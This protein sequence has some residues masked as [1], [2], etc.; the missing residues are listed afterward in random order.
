MNRAVAA[1]EPPLFR[2]HRRHDDK[3]EV[4]EEPVTWT[5]D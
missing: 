1:G 2:R 3:A 4:L 5:E